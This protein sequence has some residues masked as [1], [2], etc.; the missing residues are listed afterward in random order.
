MTASYG[1]TLTH[2]PRPTP[3][4]RAQ[5]AG[6]MKKARE[7]GIFAHIYT[8]QSGKSEPYGRYVAAHRVMAETYGPN[9]PLEGPIAVELIFKFER[10]SSH[11]GSRGQR[12]K[13]WRSFPPKNDVDNLAKGVLD[14]MTKAGVYQDDDQI[15]ELSVRKGYV[16]Y[17]Q[18]SRIE[19]R[20]QPLLAE[21]LDLQPT[22]L[23][24]MQTPTEVLDEIFMS[25]T[26][27]LNAARRVA[28]KHTGLEP[29]LAE[30]ED[31]LARVPSRL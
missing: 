2:Q 31:F 30:L 20:V 10:P 15:V 17:G 12:L 9:E 8:P 14:A 6:N 18:P 5:I 1:W 26:G 27:F 19:V 4:P 11:T 28:R 22:P 13:A 16:D 24:N 21:E 25:C 3:R 23:E 7:M 29:N